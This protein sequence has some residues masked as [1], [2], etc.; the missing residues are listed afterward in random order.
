MSNNYKSIKFQGRCFTDCTSL[1]FNNNRNIIIYGE[2]G[3]G[4]S[5][6]SEALSSFS[7]NNLNL[8]N[9]EFEV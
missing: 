1:D 6:F 4:K 7:K 5:T 3:S 8:S 2:N 9:N